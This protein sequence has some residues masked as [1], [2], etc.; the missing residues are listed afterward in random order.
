MWGDLMKIEFNGAELHLAD[1]TMQQ[2]LRHR[3]HPAT[4]EKTGYVAVTISGIIIPPVPQSPPNE[5][6]E[7]HADPT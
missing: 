4:G 2:E 1:A 3:I 5:P 6:G 7:S